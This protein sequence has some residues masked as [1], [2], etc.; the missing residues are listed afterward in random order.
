MGI[1]TRLPMTMRGT[2]ILQ[3]VMKAIVTKDTAMKQMLMKDI[4]TKDTIMKRM[5]IRGMTTKEQ[6]IATRLSCRPR[7]PKRWVWW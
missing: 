6:V 2:A 4:S 1:R 7:K 3:R 5:L